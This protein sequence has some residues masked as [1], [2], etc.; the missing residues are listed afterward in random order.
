MASAPPT[1]DGFECSRIDGLARPLLIA[2]GKKGYAARRRVENGTRETRGGRCR[3]ESRLRCAMTRVAVASSRRASRWRRADARRG[4][5]EP[6]RVAVASSRVAVAANGRKLTSRRRARP[7]R[8]AD[9]TPPQACA[10]VDTSV[11]EKFGE[12]CIIFSGV[13]THEAFLDADVKKA[14]P[15]AIALGV[16]VGQKGSDAMALLR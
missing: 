8:G 15:A 2:R 6:T 10:Y 16:S 13:A 4:G 1:L 11:A 5:V 9:A 14:T 3:R 12:A 7:S